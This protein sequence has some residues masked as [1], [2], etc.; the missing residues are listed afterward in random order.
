MPTLLQ[1][2]KYP[3]YHRHMDMSR[4]QRDHQGRVALHLV[5]GGIE[6]LSVLS[7]VFKGGLVV[8]MGGWMG[9]EEDDDG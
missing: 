5:H 6:V 4:L 2:T 9:D 7:E 8:E 1:K 3:G